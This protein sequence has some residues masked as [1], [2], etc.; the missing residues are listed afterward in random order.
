[1]QAREQYAP[2]VFGVREYSVDAESPAHDVWAHK[3]RGSWS[4]VECNER[5]PVRHQMRVMP[6]AKLKTAAS[7]NRKAAERKRHG[8]H[9]QS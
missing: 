5:A 8:S 7:R 9:L 4:F 6:L 3:G 1:L 2:V